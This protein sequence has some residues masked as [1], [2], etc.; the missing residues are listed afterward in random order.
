[1]TDEQAMPAERRAST[2]PVGPL[3]TYVGIAL[4]VAGFGIL[5]FTWGEVAG[6]A[7]V[8]LQMPYL[9]SGGLVG[10][11]VVLTGLT[12]LF[13][14]AHAQ[15]VVTRDREFAQLQQTLAGIKQLLR[16]LEDDT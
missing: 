12:T 15:D 2:R 5:L 11:G 13:L 1:M 14:S 10:V 9:V 16:D 3:L 4:V 7:S 8:A 6:L